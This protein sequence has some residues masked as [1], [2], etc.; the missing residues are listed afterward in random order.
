MWIFLVVALLGLASTFVVESGYTSR[1]TEVQPIQRDAHSDTGWRLGGPTVELIDI[2]DAAYVTHGAPG[3]PPQV[4]ATVVA[5]SPAIV[6]MGPIRAGIHAARLGAL[7]AAAMMAVGLVAL[8][9]FSISV[10]E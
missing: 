1:A 2:P 8:K 4:D 6:P 3:V 5:N 10:V 7:L 9:R